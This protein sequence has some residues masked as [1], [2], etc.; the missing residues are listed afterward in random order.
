MAGGY[1]DVSDLTDKQLGC[2]Y[3]SFG[4]SANGTVGL[5]SLID[6][7]RTHGSEREKEFYTY[8]LSSNI[9]ELSDY[10]YS[11]SGID[12]VRFEPFVFKM[13]AYIFNDILT[14]TSSITV[15]EYYNPYEMTNA[16][17]HRFLKELWRLT[18]EDYRSLLCL[19]V[20][21]NNFGITDNIKK[22]VDHIVGVI[23]Y[24]ICKSDS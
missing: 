18:G 1:L 17:N 6:T 12:I 14:I 8:I 21:I 2:F 24:V 16:E 7:N 22:Y 10:D 3:H 15:T 13:V 9:E 5:L 4:L 19:A 23:Q 20:Y 11:K